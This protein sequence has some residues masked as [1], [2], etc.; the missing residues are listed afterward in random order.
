MDRTVALLIGAGAAAAELVWRAGRPLRAV[1]AGTVRTAAAAVTVVAPQGTAAL[2]ERGERDRVRAARRGDALVRRIV[3]WTVD[4]VVRAVDL[5]ALV[6]DHVALD[7]VVAGVD[8]DAVVARVDLQAVIDRLDLDA[9]VRRVDLDAAV[10]RVDV[11]AVIGRVDVDAVI[12]RVD[13][14]AVAAALDV[15]RV[16]ARLDLDAVVERLDLV[17]IARGVLDALDLP[18][19]VR[20]STGALASDTV[21]TVR[22]EALAADGAVAGAVDRLLRRGRPAPR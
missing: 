10:R 16:A 4:G 15:D 20:N 9:A 5:T 14:D 17:G 6:L 3:G 22:T 8:V 19:I 12:G 2:V 11:D 21:R 1:A 18:E 13:V 7:E